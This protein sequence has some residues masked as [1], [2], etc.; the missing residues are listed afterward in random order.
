MEASANARHPAKIAWDN[1]LKASE[2][3]NELR[4]KAAMGQMQI[5]FEAAF[6]A[7]MAKR[8]GKSG[9]PAPT[10]AQSPNPSQPT[11]LRQGQQP[12]FPP[13]KPNAAE[14]WS[15]VS[16]NDYLFGRA[17]PNGA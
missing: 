7:Y 9:A 8:S 14:D 17:N 11:T 15:K 3:G 12:Q 10:P 1:L 6:D 13:D 2:S 16:L 5:A 4:I